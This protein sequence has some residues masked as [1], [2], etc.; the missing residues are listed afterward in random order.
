VAGRGR[1]V[2]AVVGIAV[3]VLFSYLA[4]RDVDFHAFWTGL[5]ESEY[6]WLGPALIVLALSVVVKALRWR[7]L[8]SRATRPPFGATTR[9]LL[10]G[11]FFNNILPARAG[12][13][14]RV[15]V[16]H[17]EARTSRAEALA[18]AVSERVYDILAL[19]VVLFVAAPFLPE[20][21]WLRSAAIL[22]VALVFGA[23]VAFL[24]FRRWDERPLRFLLRPFVFLPGIDSERVGHAARNITRGFSGFHRPA[25]AARA[26]VVTVAAWLVLAVSFWLVMLAFDLGTGFGAALLVVVTT[27]LALVIPSSPAAVGVFEAAVLVAL[28]VYGVDD[29]SALA[30][31][32]VLHAVNFFP[33]VLT[34][35]YLVHRQAFGFGRREGLAM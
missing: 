29:S 1:L 10:L 30:Y 13:A 32:V 20:V 2:L 23:L 14:V 24:V 17:Q 18:T 3:S 25:L 9:A 7:L 34:G 22:A 35:L 31:A 6:W 28:R 4:I 21:T 26:F 15:V 16:L 12:E 8:F 33:Y 11:Y 5:K 19:L 27:N